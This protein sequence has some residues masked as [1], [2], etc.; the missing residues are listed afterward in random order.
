MNSSSFADL[1][2]EVFRLHA[3]QSY[4]RALDV[5]AATGSQFPDQ[6]HRLLFWQACFHNLLD[7]QNTALAVLEQAL[8][9]GFWYGEGRLR[10]DPDLASLQ[11]VPQFERLVAISRARQAEALKSSNPQRLVM[12]PILKLE[13]PYPVIFVLHGSNSSLADHMDYWRPAAGYGWLVVVL[14]SSYISGLDTYDW[15][16]VEQAAADIQVHLAEL[17]QQYEIDASRIIVGGFSRGGAMA[18]ELALTQPMPVCGCIGVAASITNDS[19]HWHSLHRGRTDVKTRMY[20]IAGAQ[21]ERFYQSTLRL[22]ELLDGW[23]IS[24]SLK[25]YPEMRHIYPTDFEHTL[26]EALAFIH[27]D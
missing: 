8:A 17:K 13:V 23:G 15:K 6:A 7:N 20:F 19:S 18:A 5:I 24:N 9:Q 26:G 12:A 1:Q 2:R 22:S 16:N 21:D 10:H 14:Q 3:E 25:V 27:S 11:G 4:S